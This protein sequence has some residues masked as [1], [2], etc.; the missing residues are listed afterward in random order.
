MSIIYSECV[1]VALGNQ[2]SMRMRRI[3]IC[4][5]PRSTIFFHIISQNGTIIE[6]NNYWTQ[7]VCFGLLYKFYLKYFSSWEELN[8]VWTEMYV[9]LHVKYRLSV[10]DFNETWIL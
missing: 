7:N 9:G 1:S 2:Q 5:L 3:V 8:E 10:S 6:N 4:V